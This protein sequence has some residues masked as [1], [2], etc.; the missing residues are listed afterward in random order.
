M[1]DLSHL[2]TDKYVVDKLRDFSEELDLDETICAICGLSPNECPCYVHPP[3][4]C[5][6]ED[7][8]CACDDPEI[9]C[10]CCIV[11]LCDC[12]KKNGVQ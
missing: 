11:E 2:S 3:H 7:C 10:S 1:Y 9:T 12:E 5:T 4:S 8:D 6:Y